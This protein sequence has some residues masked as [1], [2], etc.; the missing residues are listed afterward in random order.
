MIAS[1]WTIWAAQVPTLVKDEMQ[2]DFLFLTC[3]IAFAPKRRMQVE[4]DT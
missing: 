4:C 3:I 1:C 2:A